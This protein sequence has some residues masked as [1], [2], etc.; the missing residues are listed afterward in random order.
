MD[1]AVVGNEYRVCF[2][3]ID[4]LKSAFGSRRLNRQLVVFMALKFDDAKVRQIKMF[5]S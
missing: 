5:L 2:K 4:K 1:A 3:E